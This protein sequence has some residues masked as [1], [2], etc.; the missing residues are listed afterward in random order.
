MFSYI[1]SLTI[2]T[3]TGIDLSLNYSFI[4]EDQYNRFCKNATK[5]CSSVSARKILILKDAEEG[6]NVL[7]EIWKE[8]N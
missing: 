5:Y 6:M 7:E 3:K 4:N 1:V 2:P 8:N